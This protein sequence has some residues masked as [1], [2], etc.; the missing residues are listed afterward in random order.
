MENYTQKPLLELLKA[1]KFPGESSQ[2][3]HVETVISNVFIFEKTVY[4]VYKNDSKFF[5]ENFR[6]LADQKERFSF[7]END[8]KWN[9]ILSPS[10]YTHLAYVA[11]KDGEIVEVAK[12]EAEEILFVMRRVDTHCVLFEKLTSNKISEE[13]C[14]EIGRQFGENIQKIQNAPAS[15]Q[16]FS[17]LFKD[18]IQ[19][20]RAWMYYVPDYVPKE[21]VNTY[22]DYLDTFREQHQDWFNGQLSE[23]VTADGDFHSHNAVYIDGKFFLMDTYPPKEDWGLGHKHIAMYRI[24]VDIWGLTGKKEFFEAYIR[25]YEEGSSNVINRELDKVFVVYVA[26]IAVSY[27]Y[28]LQQSDVTKIESAKKF[29]SFLMEYFQAIG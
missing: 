5:N 28:M 1:G 11:V 15:P 29:H 18:R 10:I 27:L 20:L 19:D 2:L 17:Q 23:E 25:G 4:K 8:F 3:K 22:C 21:E 24:G 13:D 26:G 12:E 9:Q 14:F 16:N 7:A 6:N